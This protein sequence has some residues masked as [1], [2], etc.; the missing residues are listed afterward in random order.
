MQRLEIGGLACG[1]T[2]LGALTPPLLLFGR[3][4]NNLYT[5]EVIIRISFD[6]E[7]RAS[8]CICNGKYHGLRYPPAI[9]R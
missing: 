9:D 8:S 6:L 5:T 4:Y 3:T 2:D 1:I 7:I